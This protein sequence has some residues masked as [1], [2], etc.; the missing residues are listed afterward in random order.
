MRF[1]IIVFGGA[2]VG[3]VIF[4]L[5]YLIISV[6][7]SIVLLNLDAFTGQIDWIQARFW[8]VIY[9]II[10]MILTTSMTRD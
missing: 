1:L 5:I 6:I 10:G 9:W 7:T 2:V 8:M 4:M 3:L